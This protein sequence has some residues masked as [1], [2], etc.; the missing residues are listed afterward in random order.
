MQKTLT[1]LLVLA[2]M[3]P[4]SLDRMMQAGPELHGILANS[5]RKR[6][7]QVIY[8]NAALF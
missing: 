3:G 5:R 2:I 1:L 7:P 4:T 6:K 8:P